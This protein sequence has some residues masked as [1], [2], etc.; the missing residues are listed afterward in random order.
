MAATTMAVA[1]AA[2]TAPSPSKSPNGGSG[3]DS[4]LTVSFVG[5]P[6]LG[7]NP[8]K[9]GGS[10]SSIYNIPAYDALIWRAPDGS[11]QPFLALSWKYVDAERTVFEMKLR[12]DVT[13]SDG[14]PFNAEAVKKYL[15]YFV[16]AGGH[17]APGLSMLDHVEVMDSST[18]RLHLTEPTPILPLLLTQNYGAGAI[19]SP[20]ALDDPKKLDNETAGTGPYIYDPDESVVNNKYVYT[21][22]P[23][24]WNPDAVK[25]SKVEVRV[26]SDPNSALAAVKAGQI[27]VAVGSASLAGAAKDAGVKAEAVPD[28]V[29]SLYLVDRNGELVD[30]LSSVKVRQ[31]L[32]YAVK[33]DALAKVLYPDGFGGL[34]ASALIVEGQQGYSE[35]AAS[36]YPYDPAKAKSLLAE[37]G[38]ADGFELPVVCPSQQPGYCQAAEAMASQ[39]AEV[40]VTLKINAISSVPE[41]DEQVTQRH[42]ATLIQDLRQPAFNIFDQML[43]SPTFN[44]FDATDPQLVDW[45]GEVGA[46]TTE[47][48]EKLYQ[49]IND[50]MRELAWA[51][52]IATRSKVYYIGDGVDAVTFTPAMS[53]WVPFSPVPSKAWRPAE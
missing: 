26:V 42:A 50:R 8:A 9:T 37:A 32:N 39:L 27:D 33:Q 7:L 35:K 2:C 43:N 51:I 36:A 14:S 6:L 25:F 19:V 46:A 21:P 12:E 11:L 10:T 16:D 29:M 44:P 52:P 22:N 18:V 48:Q 53:K 41:F 13:F 1:L 24:Y 5:P 3:A 23:D 4:V 45:L 47:E 20:A 28:A 17:L 49:Q 30:A 38:Y 15:E 40:G 34:P 31:A